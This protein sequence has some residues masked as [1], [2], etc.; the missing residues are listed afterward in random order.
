MINTL[1]SIIDAEKIKYL[2]RDLTSINLKGLYIDNIILIDKNIDT[3]AERSCIL[4]EELGHH[5][6][7]YGDILDQTSIH[8]QKNEE[9]AH[10]WAAQAI[11]K[12]ERLIDAFKVGVRNRWE[13]SQFLDLTEDFIEEA[14]IYLKKLHGDSLTIGEYTIYFDPLWVYKSFY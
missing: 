12:P 7:T 5:F 14:L 1:F 4:A 9:R 3:V 2:E 10:R 8:N 6:T 13:L 11:F